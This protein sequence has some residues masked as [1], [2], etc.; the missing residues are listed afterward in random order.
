MWLVVITIGVFGAFCLYD[1]YIS[2]WG[3]TQYL[4]IGLLAS[5]FIAGI[6]LLEWNSRRIA[7][8]DNSVRADEIDKILV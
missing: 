5:P 8:N 3:V 1:V 2:K 6:A 7:K 4:V